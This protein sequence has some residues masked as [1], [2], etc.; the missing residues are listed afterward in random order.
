MSLPTSQPDRNPDRPSSPPRLYSQDLLQGLRRIIID[1]EGT[2]Y[3]LHL[4][5]QN[6]LLLTK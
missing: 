1:H 6:K 4:T 5:R 3:T 2:E